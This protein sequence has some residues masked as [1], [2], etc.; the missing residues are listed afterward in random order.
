MGANQDPD[1]TEVTDWELRLL[2][3]VPLMNGLPVKVVR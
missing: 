1:T 2:P 3:A